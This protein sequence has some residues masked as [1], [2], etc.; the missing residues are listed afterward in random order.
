MERPNTEVSL[1]HKVLGVLKFVIDIG[2]GEK[3]VSHLRIEECND[4]ATWRLY[5]FWGWLQMRSVQN[6]CWSMIIVGY[7]VILPNI[8]GIII[9]QLR[10]PCKPASISWNERVILFPL[11]K[12][13]EPINWMPL[14]GSQT[15]RPFVNSPP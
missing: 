12:W 8:L 13:Q 7:T 4:D 3:S 6:L 9:S 11:L 14:F 2:S 1:Q 5:L 10:Y 15:D